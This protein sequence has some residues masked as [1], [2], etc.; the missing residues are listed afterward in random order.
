MV[1]FYNIILLIV[2]EPAES[3]LGHGVFEKSSALLILMDAN[4]LIV[5][6][7]QNPKQFKH[8]GP[9][10]VDPSLRAIRKH[11]FNCL[12]IVIL[13]LSYHICSNTPLEI[14]PTLMLSSFHFIRILSYFYQYCILFKSLNSIHSILLQSRL[15]ILC[16]LIC[17]LQHTAPVQNILPT[18]CSI[19]R[20]I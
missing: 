13:I 4:L 15:H 20:N 1:N 9:P 8:Q 6:Y 2:L 12:T 14:Y 17:H 3:P 5:N 10:N 16:S 19:S 18:S 7:Y 11:P